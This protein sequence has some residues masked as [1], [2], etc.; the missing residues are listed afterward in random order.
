MALCLPLLSIGCLGYEKEYLFIDISN[1][2]GEAAYF[3]IVS[4]SAGEEDTREDFQDLINLVYGHENPEEG[5]ADKTIHIISKELYGIGSRLDGAMNFSF[6]DLKATL[7]EF[8]IKTDKNENY[9]Y[10]LGDGEAYM[11][12]NGTFHEH[13]SIKAVIWDKQSKTIELKIRYATFDK[14]KTTSLLP[15]WLDWK[16]SDKLIFPNVP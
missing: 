11:G 16:K 13:G 6:E 15:Y 8:N 9:I 10:V 5:A 3:N 4:D 14:T 1:K 2:V 7:N 12:G